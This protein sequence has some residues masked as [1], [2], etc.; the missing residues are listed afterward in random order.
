MEKIR[1]GVV[2]L[3]GRGR[4]LLSDCI[5]PRENVV[6]TAWLFSISAASACAVAPFP[7]IASI[8]SK[9]FMTSSQ[10]SLAVAPDI[11]SILG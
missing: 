10:L 8:S 9:R 4:G 1:V 7:A 5:M 11:A 6:V 2:G 3:G